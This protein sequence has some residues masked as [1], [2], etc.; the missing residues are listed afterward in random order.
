MDAI[1]DIIRRCGGIDVIAEAIGSTPH[2]IYKWPAS[3]IPERHWSKL[4]TLADLSLAELHTAN[5]AAR[6]ASNAD[7]AA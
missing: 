4:R 1:R 7:S 5:E 3:G 6:S 2:A